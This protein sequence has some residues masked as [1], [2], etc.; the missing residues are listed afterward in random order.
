[1]THDL[2]FGLRALLHQP[3]F[4]LVAVAML[5]LGIGSNSAVFSVIDAVLLRP[6]PYGDAERLVVVWDRALR[7][8]QD[9]NIVSPANY[10]D[11]S[12]ESRSFESMAAYTEAFLTLNADEGD[13]DRER[14]VQQPRSAAQFD[15]FDERLHGRAIQSSAFHGRVD[16]QSVAQEYDRCTAFAMP[17]RDE[18]FGF[19]F[20]E[21]MRA[22][23]ACLGSRGAA[24]EIIADE[25]TGLLVDP[26][27]RAQLLRGVVRMLRDRPATEA[28]GTRGR[29]RFMQ[30]FTEQRFRQRFTA[31]IPVAS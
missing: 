23:R 13:V 17:S 16:D 3:G 6:L 25:D 7:V 9:R 1:M 5:A 20:V 11:W 15:P 26:A 29:A 4:T 18:G 28:M 12:R 31:L 14:L 22:A 19:V 10:R 30:E 24:A 8:G 2:R 27:D 21:A